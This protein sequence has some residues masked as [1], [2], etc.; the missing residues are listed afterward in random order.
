MKGKFKV[1]IY[2]VS[3]TGEVEVYAKDAKEA[4]FIAHGLV[5][6][7]KVELETSKNPYVYLI[8]NAGEKGEYIC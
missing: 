7:N 5:K 6:G 3:K 4:R 8:M 2:E 1:L